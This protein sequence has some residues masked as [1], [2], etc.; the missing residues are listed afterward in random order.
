MFDYKPTWLPEELHLPMGSGG[1]GGGGGGGVQRV[2]VWGR[3]IVHLSV[4]PAGLKDTNSRLAA[5]PS[6]DVDLPPKD[7]SKQTMAT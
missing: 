2:Y 1:E 3:S 6:A 4:C 7:Q 5:V